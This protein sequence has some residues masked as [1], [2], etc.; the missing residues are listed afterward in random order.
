MSQAQTAEDPN[1]P[2]AYFLQDIEFQGK[3]ARTRDS[4]GRVLREFETYLDANG[5]GDLDGASYR[6]CMSWIHTLRGSHAESSIATYASYLHRFYSYMVQ[7]GV[8][9]ANPMTVVIEEMDESIH[10]DPTDRKSVV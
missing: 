2:V 3:S 10:T 1:D 7:V 9:D 4:Y 5:M 6:D 8:F